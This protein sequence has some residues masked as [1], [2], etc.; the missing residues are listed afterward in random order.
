MRALRAVHR[1]FELDQPPPPAVKVPDGSTERSARDV[2]DVAR[3][4]GGVDM[5]DL[6]L[7]GIRLDMSQGRITVNGIP[8]RPGVA[9]AIFDEVAREKV[10]VDMIVQSYSG[11]GRAS[12]SF[13]VP[14]VDLD[15]CVNCVKRLA[16]EHQLGP[17]EHQI[18]VAKLSVSGLGLRSHTGV[19]VRMFQAL[20]EAGINL[21]LINTSEVRVNTLVEARRGEQ[22]LRVLED[23]FQD[24]LR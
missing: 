22:G 23:A 18:A 19:A 5:E 13:T 15:R 17:V 2:A 6:F 11:L 7:D 12:L 8:D 14:S 1:A 4:L 20:G 24:V 3:R 9:A 21:D 16:S 10:V